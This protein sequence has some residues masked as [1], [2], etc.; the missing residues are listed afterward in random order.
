MMDEQNISVC[1]YVPII[2][3]AEK[4]NV[5]FYKDCRLYHTEYNYKYIIYGTC[6]TSL[7]VINVSVS[8]C[9]RCHRLC[10]LYVDLAGSLFTLG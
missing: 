5:F 9:G 8:E 6:C 3:Y 10:L 4:S 2:V 7:C 1:I